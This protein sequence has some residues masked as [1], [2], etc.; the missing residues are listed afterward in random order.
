[1]NFARKLELHSWIDNPLENKTKM[2][3]LFQSYI[4]RVFTLHRTIWFAN[5]EDIW[6]RLKRYRPAGCKAPGCRAKTAIPHPPPPV[7]PPPTTTPEKRCASL[8]SLIHFSSCSISCS[9]I[10]IWALPIFSVYPGNENAARPLK[11]K[12]MGTRDTLETRLI[13]GVMTMMRA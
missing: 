8:K 2:E 6:I 1:M 10:E 13:Y 11:Q 4:H 9:A 3:I 7:P 12:R 5:T